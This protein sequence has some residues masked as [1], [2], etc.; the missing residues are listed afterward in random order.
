MGIQSFRLVMDMTEDN[1]PERAYTLMN[2]GVS[3]GTR[4]EATGELRDLKEA[5]SLKQL[6]DALTPDDSP[7][8]PVQDTR[9]QGYRGERCGC[10]RSGK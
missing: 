9:V 8:K 4:Y 2:L 5:I 7:T 1:S 3:L 10:R 6:A